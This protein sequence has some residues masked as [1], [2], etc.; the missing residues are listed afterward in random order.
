[1]TQSA[2]LAGRSTRSAAAIERALFE[3]GWTPRR[4]NAQ[5]RMSARSDGDAALVTAWFD[6]GE[7]NAPSDPTRTGML[8]FLRAPDRAPIPLGSVP[9]VLL[10]E[11]IRSLEICLAQA[12]AGKTH[13]RPP[14]GVDGAE[15]DHFHKSPPEV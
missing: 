2:A 9:Q 3:E 10:S 11:V 14:A 4:G 7:F 15:K 1:L 12:G 8:G 5:R 13:P 6:Y